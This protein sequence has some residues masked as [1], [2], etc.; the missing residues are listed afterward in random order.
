MGDVSDMILDGVLCQE[1]GEYMGGA[2][3]FAQTCRAC[4]SAGPDPH[5]KIQCDICGKWVKR[6]GMTH[7]Q[8]DAHKEAE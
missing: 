8:R 4:R 6:I 5:E 3:G 7:H 1:C 2:V